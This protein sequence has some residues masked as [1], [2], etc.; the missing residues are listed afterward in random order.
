MLANPAL[1][2]VYG[3]DLL[4]AT[5]TSLEKVNTLWESRALSEWQDIRNEFGA[6]DVLVWSENRLQLPQIASDD[7]FALYHIPASIG[8]VSEVLRSTATPKPSIFLRPLN[9]SAALGGVP[10]DHE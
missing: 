6:T 2:S 7:Q 8:G 3:V 4:G 5:E 10:E 9:M 1:K